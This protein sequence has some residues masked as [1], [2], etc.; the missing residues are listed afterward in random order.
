MTEG[1][2]ALGMTEGETALGMTEGETALGMTVEKTALGMTG[3]N[4]CS[5]KY[6]FPKSESKGVFPVISTGAKRSGEIF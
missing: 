5:E 6:T 4:P 1:E 2:T 3:L